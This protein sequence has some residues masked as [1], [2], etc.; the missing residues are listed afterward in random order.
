MFQRIRRYVERLLGDVA[1]KKLRARTIERR[2]KKVMSATYGD[3]LESSDSS[4]DS[5]FGDSESDTP[6]SESNDE[7]DSSDDDTFMGPN[8]EPF[9]FGA[10][11]VSV[12]EA[13]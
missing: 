13:V 7:K 5:D 4:E 6:P 1:N 11:K 10:A 2:I 12:H 8:L 9:S 3:F